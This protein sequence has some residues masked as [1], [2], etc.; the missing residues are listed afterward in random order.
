MIMVI[1]YSF[2]NIVEVIFLKIGSLVSICTGCVEI[3]CNRFLLV[4]LTVERGKECVKSSMAA[5]T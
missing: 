2:K 1:Q 4:F 3:K 5:L